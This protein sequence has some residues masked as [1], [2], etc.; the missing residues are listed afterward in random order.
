MSNDDLFPRDRGD[1]HWLVVNGGNSELSEE[2]VENLRHLF[3]LILVDHVAHLVDH[4]EFEFTLH[5]CDC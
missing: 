1:N 3:R 5:L 4:N 2:F